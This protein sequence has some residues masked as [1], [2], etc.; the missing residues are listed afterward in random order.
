MDYIFGDIENKWQK[1][2]EENGSFIANDNSKKEK[3]YTLEM[4]PYPSGK[5]HMGHVS[6]YT[7]ADCIAR[8]HMLNGYEVLHPIGWD[9]FGMPAENAAIENKIAPSKWTLS[10][11]ETMKSQLKKLG[12]SYDWSREIATCKPDYYKWGQWFILKMFEKGLLYSKS[13]DGN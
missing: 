13:A 5:I 9:S 11:I 7:I 2:W 3:F 10:N 6:N 4:F 8:F 1:Y 12:Y